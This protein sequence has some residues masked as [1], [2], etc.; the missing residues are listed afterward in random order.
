MTKKEQRRD[1]RKS[2]KHIVCFLTL[3]KEQ[4]TTDNYKDRP[5]SPFSLSIV[6]TK[7]HIRHSRT[8]KISIPI[9]TSKGSRCQI[10]IK[11]SRTSSTSSGN[12]SR[13]SKDS[14]NSQGS[15]MRRGTPKMLI[16]HPLRR[17]LGHQSLRG[18]IVS[19]GRLGAGS[20]LR[21]QRKYLIRRSKNRSSK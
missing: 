8:F 1:S 7:D 13:A 14:P 21:W 10:S 2:Q 16:L 6:I 15:G 19:V 4:H 18:S 12:S 11:I 3:I 20:R 17:V 5:L 9:K